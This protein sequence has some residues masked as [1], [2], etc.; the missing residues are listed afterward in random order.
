MLRLRELAKTLVNYHK[1]RW[2]DEHYDL[3]IPYFMTHKFV[4]PR[5]L[6]IFCGFGSW[7]ATAMIK[8]LGF[9]QWSDH[10]RP[11]ARTVYVVPVK[12]RSV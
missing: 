9:K 7:V 11:H 3:A 1:I 8:T 5:K 4:S 6:G 2:T 10:V 12:Y